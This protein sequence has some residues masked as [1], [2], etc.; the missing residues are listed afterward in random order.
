LRGSEERVEKAAAA[1]QQASKQRSLYNGQA[2]A[3]YK[4]AE[5]FVKSLKAVD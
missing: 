3:L 2:K 4:K 1:I 5:I